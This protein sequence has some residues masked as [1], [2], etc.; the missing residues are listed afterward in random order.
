M[1]S[2][3]RVSFVD[4]KCCHSSSGGGESSEAKAEELQPGNSITWIGM[5]FLLLLRLNSLD[6]YS[7]VRRLTLIPSGGSGDIFKAVKAGKYS[8]ATRGDKYK[9]KGQSRRLSFPSSS[10]IGPKKTFF[11]CF[12]NLK[13]FN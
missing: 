12:V 4:R 2:N 9:G 5:G 7:N 6:G 8:A 1:K 13:G 10:A 11:L 3:R